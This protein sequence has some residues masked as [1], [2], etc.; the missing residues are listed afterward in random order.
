MVVNESFYKEEKFAKYGFDLKRAKAIGDELGVNWDD[1]DLG[2][3]AQG[4]KEEMEH[5]N[6]YSEHHAGATVVHDDSLETA[7][8]IALAHLV[9]LPNYYTMLEEMEEKGDEFWEQNDRREWILK[10]RELHKDA[11]ER[12]NA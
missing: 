7:A 3:F 12:A 11:W 4:I 8:K 1:V 2:E 6:L 10:M 9:E 5:G